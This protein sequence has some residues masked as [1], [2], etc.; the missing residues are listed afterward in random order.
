MAKK[1]WLVGIRGYSELTA[2]VEACY[3]DHAIKKALRKIRAEHKD[4]KWYKLLR[5]QLVVT[6][7][8]VE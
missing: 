6:I 3:F 2:T 4:V 7:E 5:H 1:T 8:L